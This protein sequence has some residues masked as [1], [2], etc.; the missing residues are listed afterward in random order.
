MKPLPCVVVLACLIVIIKSAPLE[1]K[2]DA[3]ASLSR[4]KRSEEMVIYGNHQNL[5]KVKKA[6][7]NMSPLG[8]NQEDN[9]VQESPEAKT[10]DEIERERIIDELLG[11]DE[12]D[13]K[14]RQAIERMFESHNT[15]IAEEMKDSGIENEESSGEGEEEAKSV[16]PEEFNY[17]FNDYNYPEIDSATIQEWLKSNNRQERST[18]SHDKNTAITAE[19]MMGGTRS[20]RGERRLKRDLTDDQ[21]RE[22]LQSGSYGGDEYYNYPSFNV[23]TNEVEDTEPALEEAPETEDYPED[24]REYLEELMDQALV[25]ADE[26]EREEEEEKLEEIEAE[27][28][29]QEA[30]E[31]EEEDLEER[32]DVQKALGLLRIMY[33]NIPDE[34]GEP[35][36]GQ[37]EEIGP[38]YRVEEKW[39]EYL[40]SGASIDQESVLTDFKPIV[41]EGQEGIFIPLQEKRS[42]PWGSLTSMPGMKKRGYVGFADADNREAK[43]NYEAYGRLFRL[44]RALRGQQWADY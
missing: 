23:A 31:E 10:G 19:D 21:I 8:P 27:R 35:L 26:A 9:S 3:E 5:P 32:E 15:P 22:L 30:L 1:D 42:G 2:T 14:S 34:D 38:G 28:E 37:R 33:E 4:V 12:T 39:E 44:A 43:R 17:N 13:E 36:K 29:Y 16:N 40:P 7:P 24:Y 18:D 11:S 6:D 20:K 41:Y 25:K